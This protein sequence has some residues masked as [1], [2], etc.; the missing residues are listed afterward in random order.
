MGDATGEVEMRRSSNAAG[1]ILVAL[2]LMVSPRM[3]AADAD[4]TGSVAMRWLGT[5]SISIAS[6]DTTIL[7][8]PYL[9]RP[10]RMSLLFSWYRPDAQKLARYVEAGGPSPEFRRAKMILVGHS[11]FDHLGDVPWFADKTGATVVGTLTTSNIARAYGVPEAQTRIVG[12]GDRLEVGPFTV[13]VVASRHGKV[14]FGR[15]PFDGVITEPPQAPIHAVSFKMGGA[16][17]YLVTHRPSLKR[18]YFLSSA[19]IDA[20]AL[21][22]LHDA[23]E[24]ADVVFATLP[25]RDEHYIP[26][27]IEKLH[28]AQIVPVH[29]DD[30]TVPLEE[31]QGAWLEEARLEDLEGEVERAA[32]AAGQNVE[33][34]QIP[35]GEQIV[36]P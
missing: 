33:V 7:I 30:F 31:A 27:I 14:M 29:Y 11:H 20:E 2:A 34:K 6:G 19:D 5:N 28:P 16:L 15:V 8:D 24:R 21:Q 18:F 3:P 35:I 17:A 12:D 10:G 26:R 23:G 36:F 13:R 9:S 25:G 1:S 22:R 4:D 32:R